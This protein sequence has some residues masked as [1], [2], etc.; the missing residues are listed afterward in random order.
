MEEA[1]EIEGVCRWEVGLVSV[2]PS[3]I[4]LEPDVFNVMAEAR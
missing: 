3:R 4:L 1:W 2:G